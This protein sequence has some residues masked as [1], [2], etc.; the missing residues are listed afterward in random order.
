MRWLQPV[1]GWQVED[2]RDEWVQQCEQ[3][4]AQWQADHRAWMKTFKKMQRCEQRVMGLMF[5]LDNT[6][7]NHLARL[8]EIRDMIAEHERYLENHACSLKCVRKELIDERCPK[9]LE[10]FRQLGVSRCLNCEPKCFEAL[11]AAHEKA[12]RRHE[13]AAKKQVSIDAEY[14]V[15]VKK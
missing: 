5:E 13:M 1:R 3:D 10:N 7:P 8:G 2:S 12:S 4:R 15:A 6:L 11:Q 9:E 14:H